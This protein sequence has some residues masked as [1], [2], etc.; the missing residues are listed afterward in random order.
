MRCRGI[1]ILGQEAIVVLGRMAYVKDFK[2]ITVDTDNGS[3]I[4]T[5]EEIISL[6]EAREKK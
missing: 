5:A 1:Q 2:H 4:I 6:L 3:Y